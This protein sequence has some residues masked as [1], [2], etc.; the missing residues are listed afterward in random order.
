M[1][2]STEL[3]TDIASQLGVWTTGDG[4][5]YRQLATALARAIDRGELDP[6]TVL[7][8][9]RI[10]AKSLAVSRTTL[11]AALDELKQGGRLESRQGSGTWV[12]GRPPGTDEP[13]AVELARSGAMRPFTREG[14]TPIDL[15]F[16]APPPLP[17]VG[18]A[19]AGLARVPLEDLTP[20]HGYVPAG[21][22]DLREVIAERLSGEGVPTAADE[23]LVTTGAQQALSLLAASFVR[24][25]DS[26]AVEDPGFPN[27]FDVFRAAGADLVPVPVDEEGLSLD[28]L[29]EMC[30][31]RPPRLVYC[32]L[33][34]SDAADE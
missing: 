16:D 5:L 24:P 23:V 1:V 22:A 33:Y 8:P 25:G 30:A 34:T 26:V 29:E 14:G 10:L 19:L 28:A 17:I 27:A 9:E 7:P 12:S 18:E 2:C 11:V 3:A 32:L 20:A 4:P 31:A 15:T 21:A 6:G 13:R